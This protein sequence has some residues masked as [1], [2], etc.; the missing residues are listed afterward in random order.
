MQGV[1]YEAD[2]ISVKVLDNNGKG[3]P[4]TVA[5]GLRIAT[6]KGAK[7]TNISIGGYLP[8]DVATFADAYK[9]AI[10]S[11][12]S[13]IIA[14]GNDSKQC[15]KTS[16]GSLSGCSYPSAYGLLYP[17]LTQGK[18]AMIVV[19]SVNKSYQLATYTNTA[20]LMKDYF[21]VAYGGSGT[22]II[23]TIKPGDLPYYVTGTSIATPMVTGAFALL[24]QKYPFLT[25][26]QIRDIL[27][28]SAT[29]LGAIGVDDIYG[30]GALNI[31]KAMQPIG[32][33]NIP[34]KNGSNYTASST[35]ISSTGLLSATSIETVIVDDFKRAFKYNTANVKSKKDPFESFNFENLTDMYYKNN[36]IS[37]NKDEEKQQFAFGHVFGDDKELEISFSTE[38]KVF[39]S[40]GYGATQFSGRTYYAKAKYNFQDIF[41][42]GMNFST[43]L[44]VGYSKPDVS[45]MFSKS[46]DIV[47][48]GTDNYIYNKYNKMEFKLGVKTPMT[49]VHGKFNAD[50]PVS[51]TDSGDI[52]YSNRNID[53]TSDKIDYKVYASMEYKF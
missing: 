2:L 29:D 19:G 27:F 21:M 13:L 7:V 30:H 44:S 33:L 11:D 26:S 43:S 15:T 47:G 3:T 8:F 4:I 14:A 5:D 42:S 49:I 39:G 10:N 50:I 34:T 46:S 35:I 41:S 18:G 20:G 32:T 38:D 9:T 24:S 1:A 52:V 31:T 28:A 23:E 22:D 40:E 36:I 6:E 16:S 25:G 48:I 45:G 37:I 53:V 17:E 12:N 51:Q